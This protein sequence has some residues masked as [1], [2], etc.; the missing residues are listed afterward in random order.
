MNASSHKHLAPGLTSG[1]HLPK[2]EDTYVHPEGR[3]DGLLLKRPTWECCTKEGLL[4]PEGTDFLG[5]H[6]APKYI[7]CSMM[8]GSGT[9]LHLVVVISEGL[10]LAVEAVL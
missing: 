9:F 5:T 8:E 10:A 3:F 7:W 4:G 6:I 1:T 2:D